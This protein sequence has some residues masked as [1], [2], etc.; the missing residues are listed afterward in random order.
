MG[1]GQKWVSHS[2]EGPHEARFLR[3]DCSRLKQ[4]FGWKP[5]WTLEEAVEKTVEWAKAY[6]GNEN[7]EACMDRQI[8]EF[9][10]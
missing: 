7:L 2:S 10:G 8:E 4:V 9:M 5:V 1:Q 6:A 3:L